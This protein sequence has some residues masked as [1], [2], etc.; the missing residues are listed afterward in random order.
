MIFGYAV[1]MDVN[2]SLTTRSRAVV[3]AR[4]R[5]MK[6]GRRNERHVD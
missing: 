2:V 5:G 1:G 4:R 3:R 6:K